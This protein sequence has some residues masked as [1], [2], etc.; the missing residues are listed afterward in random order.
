VFSFRVRQ[1]NRTKERDG[2]VVGVNPIPF[3]DRRYWHEADGDVYAQYVAKMASFCCWLTENRYRVSL[4]P[5]QLRADPLVIADISSAIKQ[6]AGEKIAANVVEQ[7]IT[8]LDDLI[9]AI[10]IMD[11]VVA[12]RFHGVIIPCLLGKPVLAMAYHRKT[13]ELM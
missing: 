1:L 13:R 4:F 8:S 9:S 10:S 2:T 12:A 3:F 6:M 5:T 11:L 7:T